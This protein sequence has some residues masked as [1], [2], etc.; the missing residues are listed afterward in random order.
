[1]KITKDDILEHLKNIKQELQHD[2]IVALAL[3][4]SFAKNTQNVYSDIDIAISKDKDFL[5]DKDAYF[6][7]ELVNKLKNTLRKKFHRNVDIFDLDSN[8]ELKNS[9]TKELCYV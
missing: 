4:G 9:I 5:R 6:Y 7:F 1:M 3:F 8:S 2:G